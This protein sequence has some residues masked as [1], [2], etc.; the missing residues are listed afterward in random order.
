MSSIDKFVK[1]VACGLDRRVR[2]INSFGRIKGYIGTVKVFDIA[3]RHGYIDSDERE[4]VEEGI[5]YYHLNEARLRE[6]EARRRA[7]EE[8]RRIEEKRR[9][10]EEARQT[11]L[12]KLRESIER[13]KSSVNI[14]FK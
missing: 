5:R 14:S 4:A 2:V 1:N 6:E 13:K 12:R 3:D 10:D 11:A 9:R 7:E 8:R